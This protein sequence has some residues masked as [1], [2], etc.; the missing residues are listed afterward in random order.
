MPVKM[1]INLLKKSRKNAW[2]TKEIVFTKQG[3]TRS[4]TDELLQPPRH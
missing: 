3:A 1:V 4:Q 2:L